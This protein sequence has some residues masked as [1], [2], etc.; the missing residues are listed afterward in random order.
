[1]SA[2]DKITEKSTF[3]SS[4][5][6]PH[7]AFT[8]IS[9]V[10]IHVLIQLSFSKPNYKSWSRLFSLLVRRF[11]LHGFLSGSTTPSSADDDKWFQ[12]D[13]FIQVSKFEENRTIDLSI[14]SINRGKFMKIRE[15]RREDST[16][17]IIPFDSNIDGPKIFTKALSLFTKRATNLEICSKVSV[18][19]EPKESLH[20][21]PKGTDAS[22]L[23]TVTGQEVNTKCSE[24]VTSSKGSVGDLT[25]AE[26]NK[27]LVIYQTKAAP[28][29]TLSTSQ[30]EEFPPLP[31]KILS[32]SAPAFVPAIY[33]YAA[34]FTQEEGSEAIAD[35]ED[36][37][38][39]NLHGQS[40]I[41]SLN[42]VEDHAKDRDGPILYTHSDGEDFVF[43]DTKLKPLQIDLS[44]CSKHP[45]HLRKELKGRRTYSPSQI[46]TRS[47]A[48]ILE[49]GRKFNP[50]GWVEEEELLD[51]QESHQDE[52]EVA[53]LRAFVPGSFAGK[54]SKPSLHFENEGAAG[55]VLT[56]SHD[57]IL[58][59]S[60][61]FKYGVIGRMAKPV[62]NHEIGDSLQRARFGGFKVSSLTQS[63][64]LINFLDEEDFYRL[65]YR[66]TWENPPSSKGIEDFSQALQICELSNIT[67]SGV[68]YTWNGRRTQGMVWRRLDRIVVNPRVLEAYEEVTLTHL[69][70]SGSDHKP[71]FL[72]CSNPKFD[73]PK[74]FRFINAW[75]THKEFLPMIK[76]YWH[77]SSNVSGMMGFAEKLKQLKP[78]IREWNK[79]IFGDI[80]LNVKKAEHVAAEKQVRYEEDPT[81]E[82]RCQSNL[83]AA[84]L[85][86]A[87]R[88]A[89][90]KISTIRDDMGINLDNE[91]R[92]GNLAV[93]HFTNIFADH[94]ISNLESITT[95][96]PTTITKQDNNFMRRLPEVEEV[97]EAI[98]SLN[99]DATAGP[100]G[101]NGRFFKECWNIIKVD[102]LRA[103]QEFFLGIKIPA[104]YGSTLI[105]LVP[106]GDNPVKWK[107]YRPISLSTFMSKI[108]TRILANRLG[109]LLHKVIGLEQ[110]GF[111]KG[112]SIDDQILLA[113]EIAHQLERKVEGG[114]III[115]LDMESAFDRMS[116]QYLE[117]V[118]KKM[119]FSNFVTSLLL[120]N[121]QAT[122]MSININGKP[123]G[124]LL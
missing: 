34:L 38:F 82:L 47:K 77:N 90:L 116:W 61:K 2:S 68:L 66:R 62:P 80:F 13:A 52:R 87:W 11:N 64:V 84:K 76:K 56:F 122:M 10:K 115:K 4:S 86:Q 54:S 8:T 112:K 36:D 79:E 105:T 25:P 16:F 33:S 51:P 101:F 65:L 109:T 67:P 37:P 110:A 17:L 53:E 120:S 27:Q 1:M 114:N 26:P 59:L 106:K 107:D 21:S 94:A 20:H 12:L 121:L 75:L 9:D 78:I 108:N 6:A 123:K 70:K 100:D 60:S 30:S 91:D 98:W 99:P 19:E 113:Q 32:P 97:G 3:V 7:L 29:F 73:G 35:L 93:E 43:I 41:L 102:L 15:S 24:D 31:Q 124:Y 50:I 46:V 55:P 44:R 117:S 74:N 22:L 83:A 103:C 42:A 71:I 45:L 119:S 23:P 96:I 118:L 92:I 49:Q 104:S 88:R 39:S 85:F 5:N 28:G 40:L 111:Q 69:S 57:E 95:Y 89:K 48:K 14:G 18:S 58:E 81:E 63:Q 72:K